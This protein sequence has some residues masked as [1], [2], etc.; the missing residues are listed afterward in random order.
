MTGVPHI[1]VTV[2]PEDPHETTDA[3]CDCDLDHD[4]IIEPDGTTFVI[5]PEVEP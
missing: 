1:A 2:D 4:H 5:D 3:L